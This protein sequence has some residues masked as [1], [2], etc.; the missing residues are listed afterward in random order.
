[1]YYKEIY[2][3][4]DTLATTG[5]GLT[6]NSKYVVYYSGMNIE[7]YAVTGTAPNYSAAGSPA[8]TLTGNNV[9]AFENLTEDTDYSLWGSY[10]EV[11]DLAS[12][13]G[14]ITTAGKYVAI[15]ETFGYASSGTQTVAYAPSWNDAGD[16]GSDGV[17]EI[18]VNPNSGN[19][20]ITSGPTLSSSTYTNATL[21]AAFGD[22]TLDS[23]YEFDFFA[24]YDPNATPGAEFGTKTYLSTFD[25][26]TLTLKM[27]AE[28]SEFGVT[29][30]SNPIA[31]A[32][33]NAAGT[34]LTITINDSV[35]SASAVEAKLYVDGVSV[36]G[37]TFTAGTNGG[38]STYVLTGTGFDAATDVQWE[39]TG[40][41]QYDDGSDFKIDAVAALLPPANNNPI[42]KAEFNA[43]GT[44]LTI[45]INDSVAS[46]S[47]VEAK[48]YVD[49]VSVSGGTFTAGTNGGPST[50][51]LTGTGFD[52]D[53][54]VQW[55]T[56]GNSQ[57]DVGSDFKIDAVA[58]STTPPANS[59]YDADVFEIVR[60]PVSDGGGRYGA[61]ETFGIRLKDNGDQTVD[62]SKTF[63]NI[64]LKIGWEQ[65]EYMFW[66]NY[67]PG[68]GTP[69][70]GDVAN[71]DE[72]ILSNIATVQQNPNAD[73]LNLAFY[74]STGVSYDEGDYL[75][76]FMMERT[77]TSGG[78][79]NIITIETSQY[80][81]SADAT[82][83][84]PF[85]V[86]RSPAS[87]DFTFDYSS[88]TVNMKLAN[89]R[90]EKANDPKLFV[91]NGSI[92]DGLSIVPVAK[93]GHFVKYEVVLN[94]SRPTFIDTGASV[95]SAQAIQISG[96][97]IFKESI[98]DKT[99]IAA[100]GSQ[101][102][103]VIGSTTTVMTEVDSNGAAVASTKILAASGI[104][105]HEFFELAASALDPADT[106]E[107]EASLGTIDG[108]YLSFDDLTKPTT[109]VTE[110]DGSDA[111]GRYVLA[112]FVAYSSG[113][114]ADI[115]FKSG[116][117]T[118]SGMVF[119]DLIDISHRGNAQNA[120]DAADQTTHQSGL[121]QGQ[122]TKF[123]SETIADGSDIVLLGEGFYF[124]PENGYDAI[125]AE[126][127]LGALKVALD[128]A[129]NGD[130]Y[131]QAQIIA[132]DFNQSGAVS[133][134]DAYDIL[135][136]SVFG[137]T[138]S[139]AVPKW[140]Y[141][142][143]IDTSGSTGGASG[144][145]SYD[146]N[147]DLFVGGAI[148]IDAT[149]VLIG[150]VSESYRTLTSGSP[151]EF[152]QFIFENFMNR[153]YVDVDPSATL[154]T[155]PILTQNSAPYDNDTTAGLSG[156]DG[157]PVA[158]DYVPEHFRLASSPTGSDPISAFTLA[159]VDWTQDVVIS[160][161]AA[162]DSF[163]R[164]RY[165][166]DSIDTNH[167]IPLLAAEVFELGETNALMLDYHTSG[168]ANG[169]QLFIM[170]LDESG[171]LSASDLMIMFTNVNKN[172]FQDDYSIIFV[173]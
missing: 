47:A 3:A 31:K 15:T 40:N 77:D 133:S 66:G 25:P 141:I 29:P 10:L 110:A 36:S 71:P 150:D 46:A 132:A 75:A 87:E 106:S 27:T 59:G 134:A 160:Q 142:D 88:H 168:S 120:I 61:I 118:G 84:D 116:K 146:P 9:T 143:D 161:E 139:G 11:Y 144:A 99:G 114:G 34:E 163:D 140:V 119:G 23:M 155:T 17:Y 115:S 63:S 39:T 96:A 102:E 74:S 60:V 159:N 69:T 121:N 154:P 21:H 90:G 65:G 12:G 130:T 13:D 7:L 145:V 54:D 30:P 112:E 122:Y 165:D 138:V 53:T 128:A 152:Y 173:G 156:G 171:D 72:L 8:V 107:T 22:G 157:V 166:T 38:P 33:F 55:E 105:G 57:Y 24:T 172:D 101:T 92:S 97:E 43:A 70:N 1:M 127:A 18:V 44:E 76:T 82:A 41:S 83:Q 117:D 153:E 80:N 51:V 79:S 78:T 42:A 73:T 45:T 169:T 68:T 113:G 93:L 111:E 85:P 19:P 14:G 48:L 151:T 64:D 35:A 67:Q 62:Y 123:W 4:L 16:N 158:V 124:N 131:S 89:A 170:D 37:G 20:I 167:T 137:E 49:G 98:V 148:D 5:L 26:D 86:P 50:Y 32:E 162:P 28:I 81:L 100:A 136:Y 109:T 164:W 95:A 58:A 94:I 149:A 91:A 103:E 126:D 52:G 125:G 135:Q 104:K 108:L 6:A 2:N 129:A 147:I 56:S